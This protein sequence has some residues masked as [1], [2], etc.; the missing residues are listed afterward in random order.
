M[1]HRASCPPK[2]KLAAMKPYFKRSIGSPGFQGMYWWKVG[3]NGYGGSQDGTHT[4][5]GKPAMEVVSR[6]YRNP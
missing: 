6:G 3:S 4:P 1:K 2:S 5:W